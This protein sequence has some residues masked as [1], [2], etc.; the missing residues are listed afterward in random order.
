MDGRGERVFVHE[1][2]PRD[3]LQ[4]ESV[5]VP[6]ADKIALIDAL[7][8]TGVARIEAT[9]FVSPQGIPALSDAAEVMRGISRAAGVA[10][11]ALVPNARGAERALQCGVDVFNLVM[12]ASETHNL[13]NLRMTRAQSVATLS[14][15]ARLVQGAGAAVDA[16]IS[17][18]FG[19][20]ME[21]DV[22]DE[23]VLALAERLIAAG[24]GGV[25]LCDT[26]GMAYPTQVAALS[27]AFVV[28]FPGVPLTIHL[29]DTRGLALANALAALE[30]GV[31]RFDASLGGL[32]GC[33]Y[34]PGASGNACTEDLVHML[35]L[36]G[37]DTGV[38]LDALLACGRRL[39]LLL[40]RPIGANV[41]RAGR[42]LDLHPPPASFEAIRAK[43]AAW[44]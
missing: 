12:S 9:A 22:E 37:W 15:V 7:S 14:G 3:G 42:R 21:G 31:R 33:P 11:A 36:C 29:H 24:V 13:C 40:G 38:D 8:A 17:C 6:T 16:S 27:R 10:Y 32:G 28:R 2:A 44:A 5:F 4:N 18:A 43:A 19:C 23:S 35:A 34:A 1:V 26:T 25:T 39:P 30:A 20:P 41:A